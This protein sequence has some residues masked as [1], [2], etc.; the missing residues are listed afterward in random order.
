MKTLRIKCWKSYGFRYDIQQILTV[1]GYS[2]SMCF[3]SL[4]CVGSRCRMRFLSW[5][6]VKETWEHRHVFA[7]LFDSVQSSFYHPVAHPPQWGAG[8]QM[9]EFEEIGNRPKFEINGDTYCLL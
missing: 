2:N 5:D 4:C 8:G 7:D 6:G 3:S 9:D 1:Q